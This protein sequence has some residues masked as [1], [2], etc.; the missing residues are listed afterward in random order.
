[1]ESC[2]TVRGTNDGEAPVLTED[3]HGTTGSEAPYIAG[4]LDGSAVLSGAFETAGDR[5][6]QS[7]A[8]VGIKKF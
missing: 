2:E 4:V 8:A 7:W 1:M 5:K 6:L 3:G